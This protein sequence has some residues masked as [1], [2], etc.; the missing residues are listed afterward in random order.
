MIDPK[1]RITTALST[2]SEIYKIHE[3]LFNF[4]MKTKQKNFSQYPKIR[5]NSIIKYVLRIGKPDFL[6]QEKDRKKY[7][8]LTR[9]EKKT[10]SINEVSSNEKQARN[11]RINL[12][13]RSENIFQN[14]N[15]N[16]FDNPDIKPEISRKNYNLF[17]E[18]ETQSKNI[19]NLEESSNDILFDDIEHKTPI[20][21]P[22]FKQRVDSGIFSNLHDVF[23][24]NKYPLNESDSMNSNVPFVNLTETEKKLKLTLASMDDIRPED[25]NNLIEILKAK[26]QLAQLS[27]LLNLSCL[28]DTTLPL[29]KSLPKS[30]RK[31]N[32]VSLIK[33]IEMDAT[34]EFDLKKILEKKYRYTELATK[35]EE[36][37]QEMSYKQNLYNQYV[38]CVISQH[39]FTKNWV[40]LKSFKDHLY[41]CSTFK[42]L[43]GGIVKFFQSIQDLILS[44]KMCTSFQGED[45]KIT[46]LVE[47]YLLCHVYDEFFLI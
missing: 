2:L 9:K 3:I 30:V 46:S 37:I 7:I 45:Y 5:E 39:F 23:S 26:R 15:I 36:L 24:I 13:K 27:E 31:Q 25:G 40:K 12:E 42:Q 33:N 19:F 18:D 35:Y 38:C 32:F 43:N 28:I 1:Y 6:I 21:Y 16:I 47:N 11:P 22:S 8:L 29:L 17:E 4:A 41:N 34:S 44:D 10:Q 14:A 20:K